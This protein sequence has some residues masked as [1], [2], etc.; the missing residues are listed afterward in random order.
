MSTLPVMKMCC[1][2]PPLE[3]VAEVLQKGLA[4][5]FANAEVK[6]VECPDLSIAPFDLADK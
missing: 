1:H 4:S 6:V 5:N 2:L 3:E